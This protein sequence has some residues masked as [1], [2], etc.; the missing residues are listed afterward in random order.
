MKPII[1][2]ASY[3]ADGLVAECAAALPVDIPL[4]IMHDD[5]DAEYLRDVTLS[6]PHAKRFI[7]RVHAGMAGSWNTLLSRAFEHYD[8]ALVLH[9]D[10]IPLEGFVAGMFSDG[11]ATDI[12]ICRLHNFAAWTITRHAWRK[13]RTGFDENYWP[14]GFAEHD[15]FIRAMRSDLDVRDTGNPRALLHFVGGSRTHVPYRNAYASLFCHNLTYWRVKWGGNLYTVK[16]DMPFN[17]DGDVH[18]WRLDKGRRS[19][20]QGLIRPPLEN[21]A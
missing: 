3:H 6:A 1:L 10:T 2:I 11:S 18:S 15:F 8:I 14:V 4:W 16:H 9:A 12:G 20:M 13:M 19:Y 7:S 17:G 5:A 21:I